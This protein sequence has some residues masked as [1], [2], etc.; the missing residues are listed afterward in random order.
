[1][2]RIAPVIN[3]LIALLGFAAL[4]GSGVALETLDEGSIRA[5]AGPIVAPGDVNAAPSVSF[6][7]I[8]LTGYELALAIESKPAKLTVAASAL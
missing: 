3:T 1:M 6:G 8:C 7:V 2:R 5:P 4:A